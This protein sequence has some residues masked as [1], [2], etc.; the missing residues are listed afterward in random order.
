MCIM[1]PINKDGEAR[2]LSS[3]E[4]IMILEGYIGRK[5]DYIIAN[6]TPQDWSQIADDISVKNGEPFVMES[7][8]V[9]LLEAR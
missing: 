5:F 8:L 7:S 9:S 6:K 3:L 2:G 4:Y 1:N